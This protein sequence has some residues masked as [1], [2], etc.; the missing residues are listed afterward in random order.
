MTT[1]GYT[2]KA[3]PDGVYKIRMIVSG[4]GMSSIQADFDAT[5][6]LD[7]S[8]TVNDVPAGLNRTLTIRGLN[9]AADTVLWEGVTTD[10]SVSAN[11]TSNAEPT[12]MYPLIDYAGD[13]NWDLSYDW[14]CDGHDGTAVFTFDG[15]GTF[16]NNFGSTG[17]WTY[18]DGV[19]VFTFDSGTV[20]TSTS[21]TSTLIS[22]T[23][24]DYNDNTGCWE[25]QLD[26]NISPVANAGPD[27]RVVI[28]TVVTL[29]GTGSS[30][31]NGDFI[32]YLWSLPTRPGG[33]I[34]FLSGA[35]TATPTFTADL[36]GTYVASLVVND[37]KADSAA[38]TVTVTAVTNALP[39]AN[40]GAD[41][42]VE[43]GK[44]VT[45]N[46]SGSRDLDGNIIT[47]QW[48]L[49]RP[50]G[51]GAV[52]SDST[53][54]NPTFI[55]DFA[56]TY[57]ASLLVNDGYVN[58]VADAVAVIT[59]T[60]YANACGAG[61]APVG[62][63]SSTGGSIG[64]AGDFDNFRVTLPSDGTLNIGTAS[65]ID[66]YGHL[67]DAGCG[68][69]AENDDGGDAT[70]FLINQALTAGT[71]YIAVRHLSTGTG[72]YTLNL[73][74]D[75]AGLT[76]TDFVGDWNLNYDWA[77]DGSIGVVTVTFDGAMT[78]TTSDGYDGTWTYGGGVFELTFSNGTVYTST[79]VTGTY[80]SG[81]ML[82]TNSNT[83][84]WA[85]AP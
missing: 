75:D 48:S 4:P 37:G 51:S 22:G 62:V 78:F 20:Y 15:D 53:A 74:F 23:M 5:P 12:L 56:G 38:D 7:G 57:T 83:G 36:A 81:T 28:G 41:Q 73:S 46:G 2:A 17:T 34:A 16:T 82:D 39:I 79:G 64:F 13:W 31:I 42:T 52:L 26:T 85:M 54:I 44:T 71:Y 63:N 19:F 33:S 43:T 61:A 11:Q 68:Q 72:D 29:D 10:I 49:F 55:A 70:N 21:V 67:Y 1:G 76:A 60:D 40:A 27:Q 6:G 35:T 47:Y 69:I 58:S 8:G 77:C 66:T 18:D 24:V 30:D 59:T 45:L 3:A 50:G 80:V 9:A 14:C 32:T 25:M 84:C 65:G